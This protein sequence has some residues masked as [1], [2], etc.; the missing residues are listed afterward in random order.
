METNWNPGFPVYVYH[1]DLDLPKKGTYFVVAGNGIW[2]HK[3]T[4]ICQC[5]IPVENI[6]CLDN[7]DCE[8]KVNVNLPKI[9]ADIVWKVKNFFKLVVQKFG[10]ESE[11]T[12]YF[13]QLLN[14]YKIHVPEQRVSH[15]SVKYKRIATSHLEGMEDY[16]RVGTIHSHCDFEAFH[17]H[18]DVQ[19]EDDFDGL[20]ITF[21]HNDKDEFTISATAV[22][23]GFRAKL[24]PISV[25][26]GIEEKID[27]YS[28]YSL[29]APND[30]E[31]LLKEAESWMINVNTSTKQ[32]CEFLGLN[33]EETSEN[34][35]TTDAE[36]VRW[37]DDMK[38]PQL[39]A[40]LGSGP[41]KVTSREKGKIIV[42]TRLG[43]TELS[44][45]FFTNNQ[46]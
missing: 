2:M 13:N 19:D 4:G 28:L 26:E 1:K 46:D 27:L 16:L 11:V 31:D 29:V 12:L 17:S 3:D 36:Y 32:G 40:T 8:S 14:Q 38:S 5:F 15:G 42:E 22:V 37:S 25:L 24:D 18:T 39:K 9:P 30:A 43:S 23:N 21:G 35:L 7:L 45:H 44:E 33:L 20:H 6:S 41:F 10:A 34:L